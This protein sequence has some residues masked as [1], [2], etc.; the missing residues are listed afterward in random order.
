MQMIRFWKMQSAGND[1]IVIEA[2]QKP[3]YLTP[4]LIRRMCERRYGIGADQ[5]LLVEP[6]QGDNEADFRYRIF[7]ADGNEVEQCGNGARCIGR[8]LLDTG[9]ASGPVIVLRTARGLIAVQESRGNAMMVDMGEPIFDPAALP[10]RCARRSKQGEAYL[11][12]VGGMTV[13]VYVVSMGNPHVVTEVS[14]IQNAPVSSLGPLLENHIDFPL[15]TNVEFVETLD[16]QHIRYRVWER[17]VGETLCCGSGACAAVVLGI[18]SGRLDMGTDIEVEALGGHLWVRWDGPGS[19]V[20]LTG[21]VRKVF[22]GYL[23]VAL[24]ED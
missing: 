6:A 11:L 22:E 24:L 16:R 19:G 12:P 9:L 3:V 17:G 14:S 1:F 8:F 4:W 15:R 18:V 23:D 5:L 7:N 10:S 20:L 2:I 13:P 21:T